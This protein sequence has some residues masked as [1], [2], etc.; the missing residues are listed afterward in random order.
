MFPQPEGVLIPPLGVFGLFG[1]SAH[2]VPTHPPLELNMV[3]SFLS[4]KPQFQ[5]HLLGADAPQSTRFHFGSKCS[6][7]G[8]SCV[9]SL[10]TG[11]GPERELSGKQK[12]ME[13]DLIG[14]W[15]C[16][17]KP[18]PQNSTFFFFIFIFNLLI[19]LHRVLVA[20]CWM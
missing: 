16:V 17:L 11:S 9:P 18:L 1:L 4:L 19:W 10:C 13:W 5:C 20:A 2:P 15:V 6:W 14:P 8:S 7:L 3:G 12:Q